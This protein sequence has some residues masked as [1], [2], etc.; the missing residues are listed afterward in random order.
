MKN[1]IFKRN[2]PK[3]IFKRSNFLLGPRKIGK[4]TYLKRNFPKSLYIDLLDNNIYSEMLMHPNYFYDQIIYQTRT[5][6]IYKKNPIIIDEIQRIPL[7]LNEVHRL[8]ENEKLNFI[9]CGSSARKLVRGGANMLG[10]RAYRIIMGGLSLGEIKNY[11]LIRFINN[12]GIPTHY[13]ADNPD[14]LKKSYVQNYIQEEIKGEALVRNLFSFNKF[15]DLI[16]IMNGLEINYTSIARDVGVDAKTVREYFQIL[17]DTLIGSFLDPFF[18]R[19]KRTNILKSSKFY[20]FDTGIATY[21]SGIK[22]EKTDSKEFGRFFEQM[23]YNEII[24]FRN[25][26][27]KDIKLSFWRTYEKDEV[28]FIINDG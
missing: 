9:L 20:L 18:D 17:I 25:Y 19:A 16:G 28:D 21:L 11:D 10:G 7:L 23:I 3:S 15:L 27:K 14:E 8:I 2:I 12:G 24:N 4:S 26:R 13:L 1:I 22:F 6:K 5:N